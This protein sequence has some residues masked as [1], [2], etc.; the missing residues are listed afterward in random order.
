MKDIDKL[1]PLTRDISDDTLK[2]L[3]SE[4]LAEDDLAVL[5]EI[6]PK[7]IVFLDNIIEAYGGLGIAHT[8]NGKKGEVV[9][10]ATETTIDEILAIVQHLPFACEVIAAV[11]RKRVRE[12]QDDFKKEK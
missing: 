2:L 3:A 5:V 10:H 9:I 11:D 12:L 7:E 8:I 1:Y 4:L 6:Q